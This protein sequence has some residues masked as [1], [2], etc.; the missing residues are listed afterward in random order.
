MKLR[1]LTIMG[2]ATSMFFVSCKGGSEG[3]STATD[4]AMV[5]TAAMAYAADIEAS[6]VNW[7][8]NT[9]ALSKV[10]M[11]YG[12]SGTLKLNSG[13][14]EIK[15]GKIAGGSFEI[16]MKSL[17]ATDSAYSG[18]GTPEKLVG[19]L[20]N[21]DFFAIDTF[22]TA[23]FVI[24]GVEEGKVTGNLTIKGKTNPET[25]EVSDLVVTDTEVTVTGKFVIDRQKYGVAWAHF[26]KDTVLS[27]ELPLSIT[28]VAKK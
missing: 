27:D 9:K 1:I 12:H 4:S 21:S 2:L 14:I 5:D 6:V 22:P 13:T 20:S 8:G 3:E 16:N 18:D 11:A 19:H 7:A 24:T 10:G 17:T 26:L 28:L 15:D 23:T 25:I